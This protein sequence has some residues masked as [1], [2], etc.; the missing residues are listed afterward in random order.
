MW[1]FGSICFDIKVDEQQADDGDIEDPDVGKYLRNV[2]VVVV[3]KWEV[4]QNNYELALKQWARI[5]N[6]IT[7]T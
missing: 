5:K 1:C 3:H 7:V 6:H 2:A 4:K